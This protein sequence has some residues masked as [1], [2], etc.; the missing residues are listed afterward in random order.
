[1]RYRY[2]TTG[3]SKEFYSKW[4]FLSDRQ[5][6]SVVECAKDD[7]DYFYSIQT[8]NKDKTEKECP[9]YIDLDGPEAKED[10]FKLIHII[11]DKLGVYPQV[12]DSGSK[13]YHLVVPISIVHPKC[14]K[15]AMFIAIALG[16]PKFNSW[17]DVVYKSRNL[18]RIPNTVNV[19][20]GRK[21]TSVNDVYKCDMSTLKVLYLKSLVTTAKEQLQAEEDAQKNKPKVEIVGDWETRIPPCVESILEE[22]P[23]MGVRHAA[24]VLIARFFRSIG[25]DM[26]VA[27][28]VTT[29]YGHY[30]E[31]YKQVEQ[32]FKS[33]YSSDQEARFGCRNESILK[34]RCNKFLCEYSKETI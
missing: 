22:L 10:A 33:I 9:F 27:I 29:N 30:N 1:M 13:G 7:L 26:D 5:I 16:L 11:K 19:K 32:V 2:F 3:R 17:D 14:E 8:Y 28:A 15:I 18:W 34:N 23:P 25:T 6:E 20:S 21:K 4:K 31:R 12:W 24:R